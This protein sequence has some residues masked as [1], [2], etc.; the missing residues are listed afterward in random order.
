[1]FKARLMKLA[2]LLAA[3]T[4]C[5]LPGQGRAQSGVT[6]GIVAINK[7]APPLVALGEQY[8]NTV[9]VTAIESAGNIVVSDT[10]PSGA[11]FVSSQPPASKTGNTL[12][13]N[14]TS[15]KQGASQVIKIRL[16]AEKEG[17]FTSCATV[18]A[19][20]LWCVTTK[21]GKPRIEISKAGPSSAVVNQPLTYTIVV[22]NPGN[23]VAKNVVVTD[24]I[25]A[26]LRHSS[27][28]STY[29][30]NIGDLAPQ[31]KE[32]RT[33]LLT[34]TRGGDFCNKVLAKSSN[35]GQAEAE[36]C[37]KILVPGLN[38]DKSGPPMQFLGKRATYTIK[39]TNSG[40][41]TLN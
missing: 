8:E 5:L 1:M 39:V 34:G 29:T 13:W 20:P 7:T 40:Q 22:G 27:G 2:G 31:Q 10:V 33:I 19:V 14:I 26:G 3:G 38:V 41:T 18:S 36:A 32:T 21:I 11:S 15:L 28:Q 9:T 12:T 25:P 24:T 6:S 4:L 23:M 16:K 37:T 35:A 17:D 30:W